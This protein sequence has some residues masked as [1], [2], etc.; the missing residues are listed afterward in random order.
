MSRTEARILLAADSVSV[1]FSDLD[2]DMR[3]TFAPRDAR[4]AS[5]AL[6]EA[7]KL[8]RQR[9]CASAKLRFAGVWLRW[10][11]VPWGVKAVTGSDGW[12]PVVATQAYKMPG[13]LAHVPA[14]FLE[15]LEKN[16][17]GFRLHIAAIP[18]LACHQVLRPGDV[19]KEAVIAVLEDTCLTFLRVK[20]GFLT[21]AIA[22]PGEYVSDESVAVL[23]TAWHRLALRDANFTNCSRR[24]F[25]DASGCLPHE[26]APAGFTRASFSTDFLWK[27]AGTLL[28]WPFKP[29]PWRSWKSLAFAASLG[30]FLLASALLYSTLQEREA[31]A[32][33]TV[34]R[35]STV[36]PTAVRSP[37]QLKERSLRISR[38]N[39]AVRQLNAPVEQLLKATRPRRDSGIDLLSV[40]IRSSKERLLLVEG[41]AKTMQGMAAY[42]KYLSAQPALASVWLSRHESA[43][44]GTAAGYHFVIEAGWQE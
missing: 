39:D 32:E 34:S 15:V 29:S 24:L 12:Q 21:G 8:V 27:N 23:E 17:K 2:D 4:A 25:M 16:T 36:T 9:G 43:A 33:Q 30:V 40:Q 19:K 13:L 10:Q 14:D 11:S 35:M 38:V 5:V 44:T 20:A 26:M 6:A 31:I 41:T 7:L 1:A 28:A 42:V 37:T 22:Y 18:E 3:L